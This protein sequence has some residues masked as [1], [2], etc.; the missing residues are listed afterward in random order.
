MAASKGEIQVQSVSLGVSNAG[1]GGSNTGSGSGKANVQDMHFTK[2]VDKSSPN[3]FIN[4]CSGK[5]FPNA[6]IN[7]DNSPRAHPDAKWDRPAAHVVN[8]VMV[9]NTPAAFREACE[10]IKARLLRAPTTPKIIT[11]NAWNEWPEG[12]VLEPTEEFSYGYLE[13]I[14][15]VFGTRH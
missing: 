3:L 2:Y 15:A 13:A 10:I 5:H 6:T 11:V 8:P 12:S 7:W 14:K 4:C 9:G 1:T